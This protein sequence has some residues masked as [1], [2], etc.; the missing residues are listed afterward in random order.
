M[1]QARNTERRWSRA[2]QHEHS[3]R[4]KLQENIEALAKQMNN[5]EDEARQKFQGTRPLI[6]SSPEASESSG[7]TSGS[8]SRTGS[9]KREPKHGSKKQVTV[10]G[11]PRVSEFTDNGH[12]DDDQF[13]DAPEIS[14]EDWMKANPTSAVNSS[15][16][17][18]RNVS[19][20]SVNE[21]LD[22]SS[23]TQGAE[24]LPVGSD[25]RISVSHSKLD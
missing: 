10:L 3:L 20:V 8:S 6:T 16:G 24:N 7:S 11:D 18:K 12:E 1:V 19:T 23:S 4:L 5:M 14:E 25:R 21:A 13:F 15:K 2:L 9:L 22:L 17:H